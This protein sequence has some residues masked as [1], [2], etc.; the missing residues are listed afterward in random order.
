MKF[1]DLR[2]RFLI[3]SFL[4]FASFT[5]A[6]AQNAKVNEE[7]SR[8]FKKFNVVRIYGTPTESLNGNGEKLNLSIDGEPVELNVTPNDL[9][10]PNYRAENTGPAGS[11]RIEG[12]AVTTFRGK[13]SGLD[14][15]EVRLTI[16]ADR[17]E[18]FFRMGTDRYFVEP[19]SKYSSFAPK[20]ESVVYKA[21]DSLVDNTFQCE[22]DIP[23]R[24]KM[25]DRMV[26]SENLAVAGT[27]RRFEIAT[28]A[29]Y[30][31]VNQLGSATAA[32][33][34]IL[35]ILN[36]VEGTFSA[37]LNL[38][39][40][41]TFQHTWTV[42]D[43]FAGANAAAVL[44]NFLNYWNSNYPQTSGYWR[45]AAHLF[46]AKSNSLSQGIAY[47]GVIC[48]NANFSYGLSGYVNWAPAKY[49]ISAHEL[50]HNLGGQHVDAAQSC[51]NSIMNAQLSGS[52]P[53]SFCAYSQSQVNS[54]IA[55]N[56]GC[57]TQV[58]DAKRFD[59]DGDNRADVSVFRP[60]EGNWYVRK[61]SGGF[62]VMSFGLNGDVPVTA[63]YDGD[64]KS[65][66]AIFRNGVWWRLASATNTIE[67]ISFGLP[68][69]IPVPANFDTDSRTDIA[70]FRPGTG[71]WYWIKT[72]NLSFN[73]ITFGLNGD[74]PL[75]ADFD[76]DGIAEVNVFRPSNGT[77]YRINSSNFGF[78]VTQFGLQGDKPLL[79]DFDGDS[80]SDI[81]I[82]RPSTAEWYVL[83]SSDFGIRYFSFG[84]AGD[85]PATADFDGDGISDVSVFRPSN[86]TWYRLNSGNWNF[87]TIQYGLPGD[88]PVPS[89]YIR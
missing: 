43:P 6:T 85:I 67:A 2:V 17:T 13:V 61:S 14:D 35:S 53:M 48:Q 62:S 47:L 54:Y 31:F 60:S 33:A 32:N 82:W 84:L 77:W 28:E 39:I 86:G 68:G 38:R 24:I 71:Q 9:R 66:V 36:M 34:E 56:G 19:A 70:V 55:S 75:P 42:S 52:T 79:G 72:S 4:L 46:T 45:N 21:E 20:G 50:G 8:S 18:G 65:D 73:S 80:R 29:D 57:L 27:M 5:A 30:E 1:Y 83:R 69:D 64:G 7:L 81:A 15:S 76:G 3:F 10:A 49:L 41:V 63:D 89:Y 11:T 87:I 23:A 74:V 44:T 51:A 59:F 26:S 78:S 22:A 58:A 25:G 88:T 37:E 40:R 16:D 12:P